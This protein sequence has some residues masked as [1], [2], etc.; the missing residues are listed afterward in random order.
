MKL[1]DHKCGLFLTHNE[2]KNSYEKA[3]QWIVDHDDWCMWENEE[4]IQ[5]AINTDEIWSLQW[6]PDTPV[7]FNAV[8]APTLEDLLRL[9]NGDSKE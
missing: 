6:Y 5:I 8:A 9:A 2:H 1:P 7:G 4:A 3:E